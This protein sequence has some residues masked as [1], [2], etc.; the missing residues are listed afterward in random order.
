MEDHRESEN[1]I[2]VENID[3]VALFAALDETGGLVFLWRTVDGRDFHFGCTLRDGYGIV[4]HLV[5]SIRQIGHAVEGNPAETP[6]G[7]LN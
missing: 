2:V 4:A 3:K 6:T 1:G 7:A 5:Q